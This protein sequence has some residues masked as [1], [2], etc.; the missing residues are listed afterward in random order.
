MKLFSRYQVLEIP[1]ASTARNRVAT[2]LTQEILDN[3]ES[4][5][6]PISS[7]HQLCRRFNV[8]RV[9]VRLALNDLEHRGLIYRRHGKGTFAHGHSTRVHRNIAILLKSSL[10]EEGMAAEVIRGAHSVMS[11]LHAAVV[12]IS[13]SPKEWQSELACALAGVIVIPTGI[14]EEDLESLKNRNLPF[15]LVGE[16]DLPGPRILSNLEETTSFRPSAGLNYAG[17]RFAHL[18]HNF[19]NVGKLAADSLSHAALTGHPVRDFLPAFLEAKISRNHESA[20]A[21]L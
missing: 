15:L 17:Q 10:S 20:I 14:M 12:L 16:T 6:F 3:P 19:F 11:S 1:R 21:I 9:T 18:G 2:T 4:K 7:E 5:S 8:S 13:A